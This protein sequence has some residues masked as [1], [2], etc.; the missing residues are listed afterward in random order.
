MIVHY[1]PDIINL[2]HLIDA[3]HLFCCLF[4]VLLVNFLIVWCDILFRCLYKQLRLSIVIYKRLSSSSSSAEFVSHRAVDQASALVR[5]TLHSDDPCFQKSCQRTGFAV[6]SALMFFNFRWQFLSLDNICT[7]CM[8]P[9][10]SVTSMQ[11][12]S[13]WID[14]SFHLCFLLCA[15]QHDCPKQGFSPNAFHFLACNIQPAI[16]SSNDHNCVLLLSRSEWISC[17]VNRCSNHTFHTSNH[18]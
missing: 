1:K 18:E 9:F 2:R 15:G 17:S 16:R 12:G 11:F 10:L 14:T 6:C 13:E 8:H 5:C 3:L 7:R 4:R